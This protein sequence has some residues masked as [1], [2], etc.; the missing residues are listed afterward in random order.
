MGQGSLLINVTNADG[1]SLLLIQMGLESILIH[2]TSVNREGCLLILYNNV[3][4]GRSIIDRCYLCWW[5]EILIDT[6]NH[7]DGVRVFNDRRHQCRR[8]DLSQLMVS[9][10]MKFTKLF[11]VISTVEEK[12]VMFVVIANI[13]FGFITGIASCPPGESLI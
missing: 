3:F 7:L 13:F 4:G 6:C 9:M 11:V 12:E 1:R 5:R 2:V 10:N 8:S